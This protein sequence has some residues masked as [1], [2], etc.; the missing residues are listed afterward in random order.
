MRNKQ[1]MTENFS[2]GPTGKNNCW[3]SRIYELCRS[4]DGFLYVL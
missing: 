3:A 1:Q 4:T 2:I